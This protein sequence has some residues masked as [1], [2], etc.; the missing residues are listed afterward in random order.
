MSLSACSFIVL[1]FTVSVHISAYMAIFKCV[2]CFI[3][4]CLKDSASLL[5]F[6]PFSRGQTLHVFHL[7][8]VHVLSSFVI[9]VVSLSVCL[10]ACRV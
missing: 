7:C 2:G 5:F 8:F 4:I 1:V 3:S 10:S 9:F 6:L